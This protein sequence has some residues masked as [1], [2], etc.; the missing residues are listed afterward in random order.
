MN[1][2][3]KDLTTHPL[4]PG[5]ILAAIIGDPSMR[6]DNP[7]DY[8]AL[9]SFNKQNTLEI[10]GQFQNLTLLEPS[11]ANQIIALDTQ[12]LD[13]YKLLLKNIGEVAEVTG[14]H[15]GAATQ[16][17]RALFSVKL[18]AE[19]LEILTS[20]HLSYEKTAQGTVDLLDTLFD[21][22][23]R[24]VGGAW[25]EIFSSDKFD[26]ITDASAQFWMA[27]LH[28]EKPVQ[29]TSTFI[30]FYRRQYKDRLSILNRDY[31]PDKKTGLHVKDALTQY[32]DNAKDKVL[33]LH[34]VVDPFLKQ[35]L[36]H[37][38]QEIIRVL[39][40][41]DLPPIVAAYYEFIVQEVCAAFSNLDGTVSSR[42]N[43]FVQYLL[44]QV[45]GLSDDFQ[46]SAYSSSPL[47]VREQLEQV[48]R[49]LDELV[50]IDTVKQ[51]VKETANF[52]KIQQLR[53]GRGLKP[54]P[55][56]YHAVYTGNPGT[57]KT[58]VAR[59]MGRIYK[60]LGVLRKG[61]VVECDRSLLVA[62]YV[63]QTAPKTNALINSALDGILFI[64]EA[65]SLC[66]QGEDFGDEAIETLLK[67]MEDDRNR[68]IVIVAGYP[69]K[70]EEFV[71]SNPGLH[72][73]F[74]RFI[75]FPD[76]SAAELCRIFS[77]MCRRN[78]LTLAPKL[79]EKLIHHFDL[80]CEDRSENF[81]N[82]RLVRNCFES[83]INAQASRLAVIEDIES[84]NL[85]LLE[86][87]D[88]ISAAER[89]WLEHQRN[90]DGYIVTCPGCTKTYRWTA[91]LDLVEAEC[92]Q[93]QKAYPCEFG[94][95]PA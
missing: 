54:I 19:Y 86:A 88:L 17:A 30:G 65:Y 9:I 21:S 66:K 34:D 3:V 74:T 38:F 90:A 49:E 53:I 13:A 25:A 79:K 87:P 28:V 7:L 56:S 32:I 24:I 10:V 2:L 76:Y 68:L 92:V 4:L 48:L 72:S 67:R 78:G 18:L 69:E 57:G 29:M 6:K 12:Y 58:T 8:A 70:M 83:V 42:E 64:D 59:L 93:C 5:G 43:R 91:E 84:Q 37:A 31:Q 15:V 11:Q 55:T 14:C 44:K 85:M 52:A 77:S 27:C 26:L 41:L 61:H 35:G 94:E 81:G 63:G 39:G 82:A 22:L 89:R 60:S 16:L 36:D 23:R 80:L 51:K 73:R 20:P 62:E 46:R 47:V 40:K 71:Q 1:A 95:L 75:G 50:G 33:K 45:G